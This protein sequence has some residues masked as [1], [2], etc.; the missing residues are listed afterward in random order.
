M[1][2]CL[3]F[4][5][6]GCAV[7]PVIK[8]RAHLMGTEVDVTV[9]HKDIRAAEAAVEKAFA[10]ALRLERLFSVFRE[11]SDVFRINKMAGI[12]AVRVHEETFYLIEQ[13]IFYSDISGGAFDIT[14]G[15]LMDIWG[16]KDKEFRVPPRDEVMS[17][18]SLVGYEK[19]ILSPADM[20]VKLPVRGMKID[21]G[22]I[23]KGF[24]VDRMAQIMEES[25]VSGALVNA[26]GDLYGFG[27]GYGAEGWRVG[28]RHPREKERIVDVLSV[29]DAGVATSGDYER[30]FIWDGIRYSHIMDPVTG[31]PSTGVIS[32]TVIAGS[33]M[34]A[35][36]LSTIV[37][38]LGAERSAE[39]ISG[40]GAEAVI[41]EEDWDYGME[42]RI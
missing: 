29:M 35:D 7:R 19:I 37:F 27:P 40:L 16:F 1:L 25:G 3:I 39:I 10:E 21:L 33:C 28:I 13:S 18:L 22:G 23:A 34:E 8:Q 5:P 32:A 9:H 11:Q 6:G 36:V 4:I 42:K 24:I 2:F 30:F 31:K 41:F 14:V 26:G 38:V 12:E 20:S 15:P 17:S